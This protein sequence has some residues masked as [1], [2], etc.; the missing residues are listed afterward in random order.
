MHNRKGFTQKQV[1]DVIGKTLTLISGVEK[2]KNSSFQETDLLKITTMM[3]L[4]EKETN[5]LLWNAAKSRK[6]LPDYIVKSICSQE[7]IFEILNALP[8]GDY[9]VKELKDIKNIF[10]N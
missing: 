9:N 8:H 2:G 3:K 4:T 1:A 6:Q 10:Q 7:A 5:D